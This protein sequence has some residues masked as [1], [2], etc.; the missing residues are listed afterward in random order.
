MN[1]RV[2]S[3]V[4]ALVVML[5]AA[6]C[7][8]TGDDTTVGGQADTV[9]V[10]VATPDA[11]PPTVADAET[12]AVTPDTSACRS[13][14]EDLSDAEFCEVVPADRFCTEFFDPDAVDRAGDG[15]GGDA[16]EDS[17]GRISLDGTGRLRPDTSGDDEATTVVDEVISDPS[18]RRNDGLCLPRD[19]LSEWVDAD[20]DTAHHVVE[21]TL[22]VACHGMPDPRIAEVWAVVHDIAPP[23]LA[24]QI[25]VFA[26]YFN[27]SDT[28][29]SRVGTAFV[30]P[31]GTE[32]AVLMAYNLA[33]LGRTSQDPSVLVAH[34]LAH[35][36]ANGPREIAGPPRTDCPTYVDGYG[37]R[38]SNAIMT[39]WVAEFWAGID[40]FT[41]EGAAERCENDAGFFGE[42]AASNPAEDFAEA[43]AAYVTGIRAES[44]G[45][46]DRL[47]FIDGISAIRT[48]RSR[49]QAAGYE[50][51]WYPFTVCG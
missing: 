23:E 15:P 44:A 51:A 4:A 1:R 36:V 42:Y 43:V 22:G 35:V 10:A 2:P 50:A 8:G 47:D 20:Y 12:C 31:I 16:A 14:L 26:G 39:R 32:G 46:Q 11:L 29:R 40:E 45:Q 37:C 17:P 27:E 49:A 33:D 19:G 25:A 28:D 7:S 3:A 24:S 18:L 13:F 34:E 9:D 6:G 48:L 38:R 41:P 30:R 5:V 21:G